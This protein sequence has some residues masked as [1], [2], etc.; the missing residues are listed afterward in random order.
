MASSSGTL[1]V[2][3]PSGSWPMDGNL[4]NISGFRALFVSSIRSFGV[5]QDKYFVKL[6]PG[7]AE[8]LEKELRM[9]LLA[10]D[11]S[12]TPLGRVFEN[13]QLCG[14]LTP[15]EK[16]V[17]VPL[18]PYETHIVSPELSRSERL[19]LIDDLCS[20]LSRLHA[21]GL[22]HGDVKP[23]NLLR[24][25]AGDLRFCDFAEASVE[26]D[27]ATPNAFT[28]RYASPFLLRSHHVKPLTRAEDLYSTGISIWEIYTGHIPFGDV[29]E[30]TTEDIIRDGGRPDLSLVDDSAIATLVTRYLDSGDRSSVHDAA[31]AGSE[32]VNTI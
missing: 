23:S 19:R 30:E 2:T 7:R 4:A 21:R 6:V 3:A 13:G 15:Y 28:V 26:G 25:S 11:C 24:C 5:F 8:I 16:P 20:L 10:G 17:T 29:D 32:A 12:V 9:M 27:G 14:F 22:I 31:A 1:S 18:G